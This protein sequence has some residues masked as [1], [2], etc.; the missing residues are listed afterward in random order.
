MKPTILII[1][2]L[3]TP[4]RPEGSPGVT[5]IHDL[6]A[7][8]HWIDREY[9]QFRRV[10]GG[11]L[12]IVERVT[13]E[14][15]QASFFLC[16]TMAELM[17]LSDL[18]D[19]ARKNIIVMGTDID[20]RPWILGDSAGQTRGK[21]LDRLMP[22]IAG[23]MR[24]AEAVPVEESTVSQP[25]FDESLVLTPE[26]EDALAK[27]AQKIV[28]NSHLGDGALAAFIR[29][30]EDVTDPRPAHPESPFPSPSEIEPIPRPMIYH[31]SPA[32]LA[33]L[34]TPGPPPLDI[35]EELAAAAVEPENAPA[36]EAPPINAPSP[37][38][39]ENNQQAPVKPPAP[40]YRKP[41]RKMK[42]A[43]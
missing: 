23:L 22:V 39:W 25:V 29:T 41:Q 28:E 26:Q 40:Q 1:A 37:Q 34:E 21:M 20:T 2:T 3:P 31:K 4:E 18:T 17:R 24:S 10:D 19:F 35:D 9:P 32:D 15:A 8:Q 42:P 33:P 43:R 6:N 36:M 16:P 12:R 38:V 14:D 5:S 27:R 13:G 11:D 30:G 7:C